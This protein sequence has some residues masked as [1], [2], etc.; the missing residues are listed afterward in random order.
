MQKWC[1]LLLSFV[2]VIGCSTK[3]GVDIKISQI[4]KDL[5]WDSDY[6]YTRNIFENKYGLKYYKEIDQNTNDKKVYEFKGGTIA[7]INSYSWTLAQNKDGLDFL[8]IKIGSQNTEDN[9]KNYE[10]LINEIKAL[11]MEKVFTKNNGWVISDKEKELCG[12]Q[13]NKNDK[14]LVILFSSRKFINQFTYK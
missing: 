6:S 4:I 11:P 14:G 2:F 7:G 3:K 1:L 13:I 9:T 10:K 12:I 5:N 8:V